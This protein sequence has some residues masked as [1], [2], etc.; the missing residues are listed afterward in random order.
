MGV[1]HDVGVSVHPGGIVVA[2]RL[3]RPAAIAASEI[4]QSSTGVFAQ[5][6]TIVVAHEGVDIALA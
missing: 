5:V 1:E 2:P 4:Q 3:V 6:R